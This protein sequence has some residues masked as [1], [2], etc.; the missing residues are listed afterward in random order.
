MITFL[1]RLMAHLVLTDGLFCLLYFRTNVDIPFWSPLHL[2]D[3]LGLS[4]ELARC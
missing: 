4:A 1:P 2:P 3:L